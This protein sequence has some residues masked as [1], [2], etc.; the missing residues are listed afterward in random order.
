MLLESGQHWFRLWLAAYSAPSHYLNQCCLVIVNWTL[1][2]KSKLLIKIHFFSF[3]NMQLQISFAKWQPFCPGEFSQYCCNQHMLQYVWRLY[4]ISGICGTIALPE[5]TVISMMKG[6]R[7]MM[8]KPGWCMMHWTMT[9]LVR[10]A[11][12]HGEPTESSLSSSQDMQS[13]LDWGN[14]KCANVYH[15][16]IFH[17]GRAK[18]IQI[19]KDKISDI[20]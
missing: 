4:H 16:V 18:Q 15:F 5:W 9:S 8:G 17:S 11:I 19:C 7:C 14:T 6:N 12:S 10:C 3:T 13:G 1:R 20:W 2:T